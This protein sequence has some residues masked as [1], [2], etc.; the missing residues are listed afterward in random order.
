MLFLVHVGLPLGP[1]SRVLSL[2][3]R[4][5]Q[6]LSLPPCLQRL[7]GS[8]HLLVRHRWWWPLY[9]AQWNWAAPI[10]WLWSGPRQRD[11]GGRGRRHW[12]HCIPE[13][14]VQ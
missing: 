9:A 2:C 4:M 1:S 11:W 12:G 8:Y 3:I 13:Q 5:G 14:G 7:L 10:P 6:F